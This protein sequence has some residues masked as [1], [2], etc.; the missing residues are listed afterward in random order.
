VIA[1]EHYRALGLF[2][3]VN[4]TR[5]RLRQL[6]ILMDDPVI[7]YDLEELPIG[8]LL[9]LGVEPRRLPLNLILALFS[10]LAILRV[11]GRLCAIDRPH[12]AGTGVCVLAEAVQHLH[13][14][15]AH[16]VDAAV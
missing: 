7:E 3:A 4:A 6:E 9:A 15:F 8:N 2:L 14:V 5:R 11:L 10:G 12:V 16:H 1:L 13:L